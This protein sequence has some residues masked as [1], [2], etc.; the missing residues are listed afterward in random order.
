MPNERDTDKSNVESL[1]KFI[2]QSPTPWHSADQICDELTGLDF[3]RLEEDLPW[4]LKRGERYFLTRGAAVAAFVTPQKSPTNSRV[5]ISHLDSP[6]LK[7]KPHPSMSEGEIA[8]FSLERYGSPILSSWLNLDLGIAGKIWVERRQKIEPF[9]INLDQSGCF[10]A[11]LATHLTRNAPESAQVL[12]PQQHML[13][14]T[15]L[16]TQDGRA[17]QLENLLRRE[18][19]FDSLISHDLSLYPLQ[20]ARH[21]GVNQEFISA[22]RLDNLASAHACLKALGKTHPEENRLKIGFFFNHEEIGSKTEEGADS[23]FSH[24]VIERICIGLQI[25]EEEK[26]IATRNSLALSVDMAHGYHPG[27]AEKFDPDHTP[28]LGKGPALKHHV[29]RCYASEGSGL[30]EISQIAKAHHIPLQFFSVR[31]DMGCGSTVGPHFLANTG[32]KTI[33]L[34]IAQLAM[35]AARELIATRDYLALGRLLAAFLAHP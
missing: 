21:L 31:A 14:I 28:K 15:G 3:I 34:G 1:L 13:A 25:A 10:I 7:L 11:Q 32:I 19:D 33:D 35:H 27:F 12:N 17:N 24:D 9:L 6:A 26:F 8:L 23:I 16:E 18:I 30:A 4:S 2:D 5:L 29:Q 22:C 20:P